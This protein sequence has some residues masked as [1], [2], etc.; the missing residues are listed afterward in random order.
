[1]GAG[2]ALRHQGAARRRRHPPGT[3]GDVVINLADWPS[4]LDDGASPLPIKVVFHHTT[5]CGVGN[6]HTEVGTPARRATMAWT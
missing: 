5:G 6:V 2:P 4:L 1:M 3:S